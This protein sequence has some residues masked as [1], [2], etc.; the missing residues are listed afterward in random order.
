MNAPHARNFLPDIQNLRPE[1]PLPIQCVGIKSLRTRVLVPDCNEE[2]QQ[3]VA[4]CSLGA[5]LSS[6]KRG[7]H[8]S[9]IVESLEAWDTRLEAASICKLLE[10]L[11]SRLESE[12]AGLSF[13]FPFFMRKASPFGAEAAIAYDCGLKA[14]LN[15]KELK[16]KQTLEV[17]VMTVCPCSRAISE[18][19]AHSQRAIIRLQLYPA[20]LMPFDKLIKLAENS[21]SSP[22]YTLLKRE[23]EKFV[24]E[25]AFAQPAFVEDVARKILW[26]LKGEKMIKSYKIEV[27][28]MES[29][30]NHNAFAIIEGGSEE[31]L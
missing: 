31:E 16:L 13:N 19:G 30:H 9:R 29:I 17:P 7:T 5:A 27:E 20:D 2:W 12:S 18:E 10:S 15:K 3:T 24:T 23:D 8:M 4:T 25:Q 1:L 26:L 21:A 28:S 6:A 14:E 11:C 22:L